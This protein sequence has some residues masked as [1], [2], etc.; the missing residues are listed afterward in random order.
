MWSFVVDNLLSARL[1]SDE[2]PL[3]DHHMAVLDLVSSN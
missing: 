2:P 1:I 3:A